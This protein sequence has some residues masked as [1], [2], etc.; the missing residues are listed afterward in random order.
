MRRVSVWRRQDCIKAEHEVED[1]EQRDQTKIAFQHLGVKSQQVPEAGSVR[2][3]SMGMDAPSGINE[4]IS[5]FGNEIG[6][7]G[8][9]S[10]N[11]S[12]RRR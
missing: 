1:G 10:F 5:A 11:Y 3:S 9:R 8:G 6:L 7:C 4:H 2:P 12:C